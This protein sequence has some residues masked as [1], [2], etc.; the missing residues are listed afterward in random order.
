MGNLRNKHKTVY[1]RMFVL[2][3]SVKTTTAGS[4]SKIILR[5]ST[6]QKPFNPK[7]T[8]L[9]PLPPDVM[10]KA[11]SSKMFKTCTNF[12]IQPGIGVKDQFLSRASPM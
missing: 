6:V 8:K 5:D 1:G 10:Q 7:A 9:P 11:Q 3:K 2:N 4:S 12:D